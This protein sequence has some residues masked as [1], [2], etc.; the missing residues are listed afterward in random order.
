[1]YVLY[2]F[3][4]ALGLKINLSKFEF[5]PISIAGDSLNTAATILQCDQH[6]QPI[7]YP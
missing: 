4:E 6:T 3:V 2:F 7:Q 1:M 5:L